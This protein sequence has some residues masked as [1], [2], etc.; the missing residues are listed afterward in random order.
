MKRDTSYS[1][2]LA[3][4]PSLFDFVLRFSF[5]YSG[6][7]HVDLGMIR[8]TGLQRKWTSQA[9]SDHLFSFL[10]S[11][12]QVP[13]NLQYLPSQFSERT[14]FPHPSSTS[15]DLLVPQLLVQMDGTKLAVEFIIHQS[16]MV[17]CSNLSLLSTWIWRTNI[18]NLKRK[19]RWE[20]REPLFVIAQAGNMLHMIWFFIWFRVST[21]PLFSPWIRNR[22]IIRC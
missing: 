1:R 19:S 16:G 21:F 12:H 10:T 7:Q 13:F 11:R 2:P 3:V 5:F 8:K 22:K 20:S 6:F 14:N 18:C 15:L 17:L 4:V 9:F